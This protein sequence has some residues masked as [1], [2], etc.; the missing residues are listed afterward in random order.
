MSGNIAGLMLGGALLSWSAVTYKLVALWRRPS[1]PAA[2]AYWAGFLTLALNMTLLMP[3]ITRGIDRAIG[4][5]S[6]AYL[7]CDVAA[8][9]T[10]WIWLVCLYQLNKPDLQAAR[11]VRRFG[12]LVAVAVMYFMFRFTVA[13]GRVQHQLSADPRDVYLAMYRLIFVGLIALHMGYFIVLLRRYAAEVQR[14]SLRLRLRFMQLAAGLVIGFSLNESVR[15]VRLP[16]PEIVS[17]LFL[18]AAVLAMVV[19]LTFSRGLDRILVAVRDYWRFVRLYPLWRALYPV[20]PELSFLPAPCLRCR[21]FPPEDLVFAICRQ[22][23]EIRDWAVALRPFLGVV[24]PTVTNRSVFR[25]G[26]SNGDHAARSEAQQLALAVHTWRNGGKLAV[27]LELAPSAAPSYIS[28]STP[29]SGVAD[30]R[31]EAAY[32]A[33]VSDYFVQYQRGLSR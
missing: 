32:L 18:V 8:L 27:T 24:P 12:A 16:S 20:R 33:R 10:C 21:C 7:I 5:D 23:T 4:I 2:W 22:I 19:G 3:P 28:G 17:A 6:L 14:S 31:E 13:P 30:W 11:M 26:I 9:L 1:N 29:M 15:I 25:A